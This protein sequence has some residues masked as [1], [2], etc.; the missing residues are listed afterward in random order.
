MSGLSPHRRREP[1]RPE[2]SGRPPRGPRVV[3]VMAC[4][5]FTACAAPT[6]APDSRLPGTSHTATVNPS[7]AP[8]TPGVDGL[9]VAGRGPLQ[10]TD[11]GGSLTPFDGPPDGAVGV[12]AGAGVVVVIASDG[13]VV[14]SP[15]PDEATRSWKPLT[16]PGAVNDPRRAALAPDGARVAFAVG[17]PQRPF[18]LAIVDLAS[19]ASRSIPMTA[20]LNGGPTWIGPDRIAVNGIRSDRWSGFVLVDAASGTA[21]EVTSV[22]FSVAATADGTSVAVDESGRG[23]VYVGLEADWAGGRLDRMTRLSG[24]DGVGIEGLALN[25]DGSRLAI[26]RRPDSGMTVEILAAVDRGWLSVRTV[27]VGGDDPVSIAWVH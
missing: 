24:P 23:D 13:S 9:L 16:L 14:W 5:L 8:V 1:P 19:G 2:R 21:A 22:G 4:V 6:P 7:D 18:D 11:P 25:A 3:A 26:V 12:T 17:Q 27:A 10:V 15:Q 20:G